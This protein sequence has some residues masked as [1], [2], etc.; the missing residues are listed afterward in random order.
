MIWRKW[1]YIGCIVSLF[2]LC[3]CGEKI[4]VLSI[5]DA[6]N[7][8]FTEGGHLFISGGKNI[9]LILQNEE[10]DYEKQALYAEER[11]FCGI[12]ELNNYLYVISNSP[13]TDLIFDPDPSL[14]IAN[15]DDLVQC[16]INGTVCD[17]FSEIA[18]D[19]D[20]LAMP[21][22]MGA[23]NNNRIYI[24]DQGNGKIMR[25]TL[26]SDDPTDLEG[27]KE[28]LSNGVSKPNGIAIQENILYF[29][30]GGSVKR[31]EILENGDPGE[32]VTI[33]TR[34]T[35]LDDLTVFSDGLIVTNFIKGTVFHLSTTGELMR[36]TC[37]ETFIGP[38]SVCIGR[39]PFE[40][41][42]ILVTERGIL[43]EM[44]SSVGNKLSLFKPKEPFL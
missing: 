34:P 40:S 31:V 24:A 22:G 28:W 23:N 30:D 35:V 16:A 13:G 19:T 41:S 29:T 37:P 39:P 4:P 36:E 2:S 21:N 20:I 1:L 12:A 17:S 33:Y 43:Y 32:L 42:D 9:Y 10:G 14:V 38:S 8:L 44:T 15:I 5:P 3:A 26:L 18:I 25:Y 7:S 6:E 27:P 11:N